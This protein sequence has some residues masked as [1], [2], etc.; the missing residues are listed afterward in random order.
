LQIFIAIPL[1][2]LSI[3]CN[4][5]NDLAPK[6]VDLHVILP[7][8]LLDFNGS[9]VSRETLQ[10]KHLGLYFSASWCPPCRTFTPKLIKFRNER[11]MDFEVILVGMDRSREDQR[12]Y[13]DDYD[14]PWPSLPHDSES[15][16][17]LKALFGIKS[18]PTLIILSPDGVVVSTR[19][20]E[21]ISTK[22]SV[23][24]DG[25]LVR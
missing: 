17:K 5:P 14:M 23:A 2:L 16:S 8:E 25:W 22:G 7:R 1:V 6:K 4:S 15:L 18:I 21:E 11:L 24:F 12:A 19:G 3:G 9:L 13:V 10:G 20:R